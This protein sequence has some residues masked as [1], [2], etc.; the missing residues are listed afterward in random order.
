MNSGQNFKNLG[1]IHGI[2]VGLMETNN[3]RISSILHRVCVDIFWNSPI[4]M[5]TEEH[6]GTMFCELLALSVLKLWRTEIYAGT[7]PDLKAKGP[8]EIHTGS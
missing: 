6:N 3:N 5:T 4:E 2:L 8:E 1:E 7:L